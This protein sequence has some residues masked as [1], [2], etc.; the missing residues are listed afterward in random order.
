MAMK[1][2]MLGWE[3]EPSIDTWSAQNEGGKF[4][5]LSPLKS[6]TS[7]LISS[8]LHVLPGQACFLHTSFCMSCQAFASSSSLF[9]NISSSLTATWQPVHSA[10]QTCDAQCGFQQIRQK[11]PCLHRG[12]QACLHR[13]KYS[14]KYRYDTCLDRGLLGGYE[15]HPLLR[16]HTGG[17]SSGSPCHRRRL[18]QSSAG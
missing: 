18:R 17:H 9:A 8:I 3:S 10:N 2:I 14:I 15:L 4:V 5:L 16:R 7:L 6:H 12:V 11:H 13:W 1:R